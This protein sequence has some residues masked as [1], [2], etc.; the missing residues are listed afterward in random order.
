MELL[1]Y[2]TLLSKAPLEHNYKVCKMSRFILLGFDSEIFHSG[3]KLQQAS[4]F[5]GLLKIV[6]G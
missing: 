6:E 2:V 4:S 5:E 3:C 1:E